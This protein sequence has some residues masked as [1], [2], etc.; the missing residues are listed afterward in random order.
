MKVLE[1][2]S[3]EG[4]NRYEIHVLNSGDVF[5]NFGG[6]KHGLVAQK[7][8]SLV[9]RSR[10]VDLRDVEYDIYDAGV[11][12]WIGR[13]IDGQLVTVVRAEAETITD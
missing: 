9:V 11:W 12:A 6:S 3:I 8:A 2:K 1:L 7:T 5:E 4:H 10:G 13:L